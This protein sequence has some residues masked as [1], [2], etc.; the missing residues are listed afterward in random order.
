MLLLV[1]RVFQHFSLYRLE[2]SFIFAT[3]HVG[4]VWF[5]SGRTTGVS[6]VFRFTSCLKDVRTDFFLK[7]LPLKDDELVMSEM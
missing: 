4:R 5:V 2:Y 7:I 3:V 6:G 1:S